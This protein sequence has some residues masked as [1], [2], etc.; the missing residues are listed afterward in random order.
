ME[1]EAMNTATNN[2]K[3]NLKTLILVSPFIG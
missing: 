1:A 3:T 2:T